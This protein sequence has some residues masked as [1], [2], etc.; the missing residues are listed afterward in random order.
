MSQENVQV[1]RKATE[2][3][4][5]REGDAWWPLNDPNGPMGMD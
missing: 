3:F 1:V 2:A 4:N 5:R